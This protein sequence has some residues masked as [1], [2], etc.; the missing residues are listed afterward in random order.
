MDIPIKLFLLTLF[1]TGQVSEVQRRGGGGQVSYRRKGQRFA[2]VNLTQWIVGKHRYM[3]VIF[4]EL[5]V[6][7]Q[8]E[9]ML[10]V[11]RFR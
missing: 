3:R 7:Y 4:F 8:I 9:H 1:F 11:L 5:V 6:I 10:T 2:A